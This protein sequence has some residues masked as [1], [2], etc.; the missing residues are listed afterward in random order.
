M[1][2]KDFEHSEV[3]CGAAGWSKTPVVSMSDNSA[4]LWG[5]NAFI[6]AFYR[7]KSDFCHKV[8]KRIK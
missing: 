1:L 4:A 8:Y 5:K 7:K 3:G 6:M 2:S